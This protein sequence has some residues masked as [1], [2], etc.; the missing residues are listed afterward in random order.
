MNGDAGV[1]KQALKR[2]VRPLLIPIVRPCIRYA[3]H[4]GIRRALWVSLIAPFFQYAKHPFVAT[5]KYGVRIAGNTEDFIQ[6]YIYYFG[7]WEP[8]L[9]EFVRTRLREGDVF[10]DVGANIG[11]FTL[12][13]SKLV[14]PAGKVIAIEASPRIFAK[15]RANL[16]RNHATNV[17]ARNLAASDRRGSVKVYFASDSNIGETSIGEKQGSHFEAEVPADSLDSLLTSQDLSRVRLVKIDV[18]GAEWLVL[19]GMGN[20]LR[21]GHPDLEVVVELRP[22]SLDA[23][24]KR[25]EDVL[26]MFSALGFSPYNLDNDYDALSYVSSGDVKRPARIRTPILSQTDIVFSRKDADTL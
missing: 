8:D 18:E 4:E 2:W 15:L 25:V 16:E 24:G 14:G 21:N 26:S 23:Y 13:A 12:L 10:V 17:D 9:T 20:L 6:R 1:V 3:P 7:V 11:Y 19:S 5:T 22:Q